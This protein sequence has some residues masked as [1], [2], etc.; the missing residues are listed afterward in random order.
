MNRRDL[1]ALLGS[2]AA[3]WPLGA[4]AQQSK[5]VP[6]LCF[7]TFDPGTLQATRFAFLCARKR[8]ET[9]RMRGLVVPPSLLALA[10]EVIE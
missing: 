5:K 8:A 3:A 7:L 2:T 1:I 4:R 10:D 6:R 9:A